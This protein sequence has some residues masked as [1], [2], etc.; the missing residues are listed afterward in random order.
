MRLAD[1]VQ[2]DGENVTQGLR[3]RNVRRK[4]A[5]PRVRR[6]NANAPTAGGNAQG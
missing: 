3:P 6:I 2:I 1:D 4:D 5:F